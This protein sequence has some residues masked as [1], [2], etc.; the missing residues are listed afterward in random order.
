MHKLRKFLP[1]AR[2][3]AGFSWRRQ[4]TQTEE[5]WAWSMWF[6]KMGVIRK[7]RERHRWQIALCLFIPLLQH[8]SAGC[9]VIYPRLLRLPR[10]L[11]L[12][13]RYAYRWLWKKGL[14]AMMLLVVWVECRNNP[15]REKERSRQK[16]TCRYP[17]WQ[18]RYLSS[19]TSA[20]PP[21]YFLSTAKQENI[22]NVQLHFPSPSVVNSKSYF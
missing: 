4:A 15:K 19:R 1:P 9:D 8:P 22:D 5:S 17:K 12:L 18:H 11:C 13:G 6:V 16:Q 7:R 21:K 3:R 10:Y 2:A 14:R 20:S